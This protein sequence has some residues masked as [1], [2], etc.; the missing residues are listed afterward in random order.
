MICLV[1]FTIFLRHNH[2]N[3]ERK[4]KHDPNMLY[5]KFFDISVKIDLHLKILP[6]MDIVHKMVNQAIRVK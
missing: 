6:K 1:F 2:E 4:S 5:F 3:L